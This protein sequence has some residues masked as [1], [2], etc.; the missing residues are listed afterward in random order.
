MRHTVL[1][2][3]SRAERLLMTLFWLLLLLA[4]NAPPL[5]ML[6]LLC[7]LLHELGHITA[8]ALLGRRTGAPMERPNGLLLPL[9]GSLSYVEECFVA[10]MGPIA[11]LLVALLCLLARPLGHSFFSTFA[12]LSL[13]TAVANLLPVGGYDGERML[14]SLLSLRL[15]AVR[16]HAV[17]AALSLGL[18]AVLTLVSLYGMLRVGGGYWIFGVFFATLL[19]EIKRSLA[20][21]KKAQDP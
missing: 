14:R 4:F 16:A 13:F 2:L 3:L 15:D 6:T 7:A 12:I 10:A 18:S 5:A 11:N 1:C 20:H 9:Q 8:A 17:C 21:A 19:V